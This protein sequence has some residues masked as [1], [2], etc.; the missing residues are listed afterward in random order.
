LRDLALE[1]IGEVPRQ[2]EARDTPKLGKDIAVDENKILDLTI[3]TGNDA[4]LSLGATI[5]LKIHCI[6][7]K[8][9]YTFH[10]F[11]ARRHT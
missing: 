5:R 10:L 8:H 9:L 6:A 1:S 11:V 4:K 7:D 2:Y 3:E